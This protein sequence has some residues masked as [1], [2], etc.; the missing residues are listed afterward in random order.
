LNDRITL[1]N[2]DSENLK[3][4]DNIFDAVIVAFGVRNFENL[5]SGLSGMHRVLRKNGRVVVLE[6]SKPTMF[7]FKQLYNFYFNVDFA[8]NRKSDFQG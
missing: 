3:F 2:G 4:E 8:Y 6:F 5:H 1:E 7:P